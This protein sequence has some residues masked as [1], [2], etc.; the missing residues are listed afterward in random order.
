MPDTRTAQQRYDAATAYVRRAIKHVHSGWDWFLQG[1]ADA[2]AGSLKVEPVENELRHIEERWMRATTESERMKVAID[3][4]NLADRTKEN[5]PGAPQDWT[6]TN[7]YHGEAEHS[8]AATSYSQE[9]VREAR[10]D[11]NW[12]ASKATSTGEKTAGV[13]KLLLWGGGIYLGI[14]IVDELGARRR[15]RSD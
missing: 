9:V 3:A 13:A 4:E 5:L 8:T 6:R 10:D 11:W 14:K 7:L 12:V 1:A 2:Y 15:T